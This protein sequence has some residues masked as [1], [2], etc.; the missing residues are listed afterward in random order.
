MADIPT[1]A[2]TAGRR[3]NLP[4]L[5]FPRLAIGVSL[6][7]MSSLMGDALKMAYADPYA[8]VR[9]KAP[10]A[11]DDDLEGRDPAW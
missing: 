2:P 1:T 10:A 8:S 9:R 3:L 6:N 11:P 7:A 5:V 4:R